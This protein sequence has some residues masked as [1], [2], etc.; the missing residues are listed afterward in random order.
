MGDVGGGA[1]EVDDF[2]GELFDGD[3]VAVADVVGAVHVCMACGVGEGG[4]DV[5]DEDEV[6]GLFAIAEDGDGLVGAGFVDEDGD[7]GGVG[8]VGV[9][10]RAEDVE[11]AQG[12]GVDAAFAVLMRPSRRNIS[13]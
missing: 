13:R 4:C 9:L 3:A 1:G 11:E 7:G 2:L 6:A 5:L 10:A 8:A 12:R